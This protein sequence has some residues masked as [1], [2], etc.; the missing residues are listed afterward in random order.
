[1][2]HLACVHRLLEVIYD[3]RTSCLWLVFEYVTADLKRFL[4]NISVVPQP[5][6]STCLTPAAHTSKPSVPKSSGLPAPH[7]KVCSQLAIASAY[8]APTCTN[9]SSNN[10]VKGNIL[11]HLIC[12]PLYSNCSP[13]HPTSIPSGL[14]IGMRLCASSPVAYN[15]S[16]A[17]CCRDLKPQNI[18]VD[19]DGTLK[20]A[21]F[22]LARAVSIFSPRSYTREVRTHMPTDCHYI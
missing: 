17:R 1:M 20:I 19:E 5:D 12:S 4:D 18:L 3:P 8:F 2:P 11:C 14:F 10:S 16:M 22:G 7:V 15:V 21:D 9:T 6:T 13:P